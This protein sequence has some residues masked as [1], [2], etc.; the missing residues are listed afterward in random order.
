VRL[1]LAL[2][3]LVLVFSPASLLAA[4][5]GASVPTLEELAARVE[6]DP[7][8][9]LALAQYGFALLDGE[10]EE[11]GR[12]LLAQADVM[13][14]D[15]PRV[16][17]VV[18]RA[19]MKLE[20]WGDASMVA[21]RVLNS[22]LASP[23]D[24]VEAAFVGG[25]ARWRLGDLP[26]AEDLY[27]RALR[28]DPDHGP[29]MLN[30]G[31]IYYST[32]RHAQ[33]IAA[34]QRAAEIDQD[35]PRVAIRVAGAFE[36]MGRFELAAPLRERVVELLPESVGARKVLV[37]D[38]LVLKKREEALPHLAFLADAEP[39]VGLHRVMMAQVLISL[40]RF[41]EALEHAEAALALGEASQ[42]LID[43]ARSALESSP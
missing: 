41:E 34:L 36:G 8:N 14:F 2:F 23:Q 17:I 18:A 42:P 4:G 3:T 11:E 13:G 24:K 31:L 1:L 20:N 12:E 10:R 30:L 38:L 43:Q 15:E 29:S 33:G 37:Q 5:E 32:S 7:D 21:S 6:S 39:E 9:A 27:G 16:Q 35:N 22:A 28:L 26:S 25:S 19:H 40:G